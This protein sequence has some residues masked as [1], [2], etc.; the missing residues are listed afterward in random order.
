MEQRRN[1]NGK[2]K[3]LLIK[4]LYTKIAGYRKSGTLPKNVFP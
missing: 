1:Q 2:L 4:I 3:T